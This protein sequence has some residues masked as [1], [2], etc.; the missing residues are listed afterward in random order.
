MKL[1]LSNF[2]KLKVK[3]ILTF[4]SSYKKGG[5]MKKT[6][7]KLRA[8]M[9]MAQKELADKLGIPQSIYF[10]IENYE[11]PLKLDKAILFYKLYKSRTGKDINF[12]TN[13][14]HLI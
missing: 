13:V 4:E 8:E 1:K 6:Y 10:Y 12:L 3:K 14:K 9:G 11:M 5:Q 7:K 2:F